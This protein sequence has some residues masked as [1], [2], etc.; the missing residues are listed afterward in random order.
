MKFQKDSRFRVGLRHIVDSRSCQRNG[1]ECMHLR[2]T[3]T[4][5]MPIAATPVTP[6]VPSTRVLLLRRLRPSLCLLQLGTVGQ[7]VTQSSAHGATFQ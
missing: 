4:L 6:L 5:L 7:S 1:V 2:S 3:T